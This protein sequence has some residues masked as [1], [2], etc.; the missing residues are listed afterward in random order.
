MDNADNRRNDG[1]R[2]GR[3][4]GRPGGNRGGF[5][6]RGGDRRGGGPRRDGERR[7]GRSGGH[8]SERDGGR[9]FGRDDRRGGKRFDKRDGSGRDERR[10]GYR[11][12]GDGKRFD[13]RDDRRF[14]RDGGKRFDRRDDRGYS[15]GE[16]QGGFRGRD[17]KRFDRSGRDDRRD[18]KRFDRRDD[19]G[20][21]KRDDRGFDRKGAG[22]RDGFARRDGDRQGFGGRGR[23]DNPY[24]SAGKPDFKKRAPLGDDLDFKYDKEI[25][26][27]VADDS[28]LEF[29]AS[30]AGGLEFALASELKDQCGIKRTRPLR[31][32]VAFYGTVREAY[33][34]C[35]WSRLASRVFYV[36]GRCDAK[37]EQELYDGVKAM[38][39][40]RQIPVGKTISV[41]A[42]GTND[43][44]RNT[45][46]TALRAKDG[47]CDALRAGRGKRPDVNLSK[48]DVLIDV[49][50]R[51]DR[52][53]VSIDLCST[54]LHHRSYERLG[55]GGND[56]TKSALAAAALESS[57]WQRASKEGKP[58]VD[59]MARDGYLV[60]EA[61]M[62]AA[63]MAPSLT[64]ERW[65]FFGWNGHDEAAWEELLE[66]AEDRLEAALES[67]PP[68]YALATDERVRDNIVSML[69]RAG[70]A[71]YV[72]VVDATDER[73]VS[74]AMKALD[75]TLAG[76]EA[77]E[78]ARLEAEEAVE[79]SAAL[80]A[81]EDASEVEAAADEAAADEAVEAGADEEPEAAEPA[82][83]AAGEQ[84]EAAEAS[85]DSADSEGDEVEEAL[86]ERRATVR[87]VAATI[88]PFG[89]EEMDALGM[90]T[91]HRLL[92]VLTMLPRNWKY[93]VIS[94]NDVVERYIASRTV[95]RPEAIRLGKVKAFVRRYVRIE[96]AERREVTVFDVKANR[97]RVIPVLEQTSEQFAARLKKNMKERRKWADRNF[98]TCYRV[99][100]ADLPDY[101]VAI[102]VYNGAEESRGETFLVIAEYQAPREIDHWRAANRL[103][104]VLTL[105]PIVLGVDADK[106]FNR[107]R[108]QEKGGGQYR[109]AGAPRSRKAA[110]EENGCMFEVDFGT[111]LDTGLFLDQRITRGKV[112]E[113]A[114]G[115]SFLN[116]FAYTGTAT[117]HAAVA[118]AKSTLT[119]DLSQT[120]LDWAERNMVKNGLEGREHRYLRIDC[121]TWIRN[122]VRVG[123]QYGVIYVDP[124]TF[125]NSKSMGKDTWS[126]QRD[127]VE[128]LTGVSR[129]LE[130][131]GIAVFSC[132]LRTF[133]PE[134]EELLSRGIIMVDVTAE[135]IPHDFERNP[136]IHRCYLVAKAG[137]EDALK[138]A[139]ELFG[140]ELKIMEPEP[141]EPEVEEDVILVEAEDAE[142]A[143][144]EAAEALVEDEA[145]DA[146]ASDADTAEVEREDDEADDAEGEKDNS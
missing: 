43:E 75:G 77:A 105:A 106:V 74:R 29:F 129:L 117:V 92:D 59:P 55:A 13:K 80:E 58:F 38:P 100:D 22:S 113:L 19:R 101:A 86:R 135:T 107:T 122:E 66:E 7:D 3:G 131:D 47:L 35:L 81:G 16:R 28:L 45:Q 108:K 20:F 36:V 93:V 116:L 72:E 123:R 24:R 88:L 89:Q 130:D 57:W 61:A 85:D 114:V 1:P 2:G 102:D 25:D 134:V 31:G 9:G 11:G 5:G 51:M 111:Y 76:L 68:I 26:E 125:S 17:D 46:F 34:A 33:T 138:S 109:N 6:G 84:A 44:L 83:P 15:H 127:H 71:Q 146:A 50:I 145:E 91:Y 112:A 79:A 94:D 39:W 69:K 64:R 78:L 121:M 103:R 90:E 30:C 8:R 96:A 21:G 97:E 23:S 118:G 4:G 49:N 37:N 119:I 128:L 52:A 48:P 126:V 27:W 56:G 70:L 10:G 14:D 141:E 133:K 140:A 62:V 40:S 99:Y 142:P 67:M 82:E 60:T 32:G 12:N 137:H 41:Y 132:N 54:S 139:C 42:H 115:K 63:D 144:A 18:G 95:V 73:A 124:P 110:V 104:D 65:G 143:E 87:G 98:V 136:R 120:Y 53:T